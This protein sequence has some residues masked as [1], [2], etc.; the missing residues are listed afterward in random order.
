MAKKEKREK[1]MKTKTCFVI[2]ICAMVFGSL[3]TPAEAGEEHGSGTVTYAPAEVENTQLPD[4][5]M[6]QRSHIMGIVLADD[7]SNSIHLA[8]QDCFGTTVVPDGGT[9][10]G[11]GYCDAVDANGDR[12]WIWWHN[13]PDSNT[14][15]FMG[16]TGK[17]EGIT[18]GGTTESLAQMADG[19]AAITW[20][21]HWTM[22]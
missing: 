22:K 17:Y 19:R 18:G 16:G 4:G 15:G 2:A 12:W 14:W 5:G 10:I 6:I 21:G 11:N 20:D 1:K 3:V 9:A 8:S 7:A 13:G